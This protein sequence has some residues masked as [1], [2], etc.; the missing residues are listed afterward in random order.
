MQGPA[1]PGPLLSH[2][3]SLVYNPP[4]MIRPSKDLVGRLLSHLVPAA[5][6]GGF[7]ILRT[8]LPPRG[9]DTLG[10]AAIR[11]AI[12]SLAFLALIVLLSMG[13]GEAILGRLRVPGLR[14]PESTLF[15]FALGIGAL[16]LGITALGLVG[17]LSRAWISALLVATAAVSGPSLVGLLRRGT[18]AVRAI[19]ALWRA[20]SPLA[21][22][23]TLLAAAIGLMALAQALTPPWDYDGLMYHL[24]GPRLFLQAGRIFAYPDNWYVNGPFSIE[25]LFSIGMAFGD[26][27]LP[28]LIHL[29]FSVVLLGATWAAARRWLAEG[30]AWVAPAILLTVPTLPIFSSFAYIDL[31]WS[32]YE[33]LALLALVLWWESRSERLLVLAG[34]MIGFAMGSK[35]LGLE[36]FA[37][38][39]LLILIGSRTQ[40]IKGA[41]RS[42]LAFGLPAA[43]IALPWYLKNLIWFGNPV[44]PLYFGG[45]EWDPTRLGLYSAYLDSFGVGRTLV[46]YLLLP[47]N[48]YARQVSFGAVMNRID[49]PSLLFPLALA[50]PFTK[51]A[52]AMSILLA[53]AAGRFIFWAAG[54]QQTRFLLPIYPALALGAA[55]VIGRFG[56]R[57]RRGSA[58]P[59][60][61][62][63]LALGLLLITLYYQTAVN[64]TGWRTVVGLE[65]KNDF[66]T[67]TIYDYPAARF[68][69]SSLQDESR[70]LL[71]GDGQS[72]YCPTKCIPDPDHFRWGN[73]IHSAA[74][75]GGLARW[76]TDQRISHLFF[77]LGDFDFL[78]QHDPTGII[79]SVYADLVAFSNQ[80]CLEEVFQSE[81]VTVFEIVCPH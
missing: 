27:I 13:S 78:L 20:A 49:I 76:F 40:G 2:D 12:M 74:Q 57:L 48:V 63:V 73:L 5:G 38:L 52:R 72:Y 80:G 79:H 61:F 28:K 68:I 33:F 23:F 81:W 10:L 24:V 22:A 31:G 4:T 45:P 55:H 62:P 25:M 53:I 58:L 65:T 46:D 50:Y 26:D 43:V 17:L 56:S 29:G 54:S 7:L 11:D 47:I 59:L 15:G 70:V 42:G 19:P 67:E 71:V 6:V 66:L 35:Y 51:R 14:R 21:R 75:H 36:G 64:V 77:S 3:L 34:L 69:E 18:S 32:S 60:F 44:F 16:S 30:Q 8:L 1:S 9:L 37:L 41:V 39:G